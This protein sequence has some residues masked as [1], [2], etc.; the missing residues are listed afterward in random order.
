MHSNLGTNTALSDGFSWDAT[1]VDFMYTF[2]VQMR[3][4]PSIYQVTGANYFKIQATGVT[5]YVDGNWTLQYASKFATSHYATSDGSRTAGDS[6][7]ITFNNTAARLG[8]S[9]EL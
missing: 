4:T 9:A 3:A 8:Y 7:H 5:T 6:C 1:E 2:P